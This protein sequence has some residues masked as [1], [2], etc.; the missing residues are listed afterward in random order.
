MAFIEF[1]LACVEYYLSRS[2]PD[3]DCTFTNFRSAASKILSECDVI[4]KLYL[5]G[6]P[7]IGHVFK[8]RFVASALLPEF[9][10]AYCAVLE[11]LM[12]AP[13]R[14]CMFVS[15][16][17][18]IL[19]A[20]EVCLETCTAINGTTANLQEIDAQRL[21]KS[22]PDKDGFKTSVSNREKSRY[23][24][25]QFHIHFLERILDDRKSALEMILT[26]SCFPVIRPDVDILLK[27]INAHNE[28]LRKEQSE[29][30]YVRTMQ[31][32]LKG[33]R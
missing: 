11:G 1:F 9:D 31:A 14:R 4:M 30:A 12:L 19:D 2:N 6:H 32:V 28:E 25:L 22:K 10:A 33:K 7:E 18:S 16:A 24:K 23:S 17:K 8:Q 3:G 13:T 20:L 15:G 27:T 5:C 26:G 21:A 29:E